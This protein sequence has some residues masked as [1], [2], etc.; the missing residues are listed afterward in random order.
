MTDWLAGKDFKIQSGPYM[1]IRDCRQ[2]HQSGILMIA[3]YSDGQLQFFVSTD[4]PHE[5]RE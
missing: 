5:I 4:D 2:M 1:S 3:F